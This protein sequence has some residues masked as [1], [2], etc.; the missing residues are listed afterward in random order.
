MLLRQCHY[1]SPTDC[2]SAT[3]H[4]MSDFVCFVPFVFFVFQKTVGWHP[5]TKL[6]MT[7]V[8]RA[9]LPEKE[10]RTRLRKRAREKLSVPQKKGRHKTDPYGRCKVYICLITSAIP[11]FGRQNCHPKHSDGRNRCRWQRI[12]R[13]HLFRPRRLIG[14]RMPYGP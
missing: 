11:V 1:R 3:R 9:I 2:Q 14:F 12:C 4:I 5:S 10:T 7:Y 6:R 13:C 8:A